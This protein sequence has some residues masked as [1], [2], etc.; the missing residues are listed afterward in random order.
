M[1]GKTVH[2]NFGKAYATK[3]FDKGTL[4]LDIAALS[5][6]VEKL[7]LNKSADECGLLAEIFKHMPNNFAAKTHQE[8][9]S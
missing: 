8:E 1:L 9:F 6:A 4:A 3:S 5:W 7:K 2:W